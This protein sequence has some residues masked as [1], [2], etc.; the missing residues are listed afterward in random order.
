MSLLRLSSLARDPTHVPAQSRSTRKQALRRSPRRRNCRPDQPAIGAM[1]PKISFRITTAYSL[2]LLR[3][4]VHFEFS[5]S[6]LP[7]WKPQSECVLVG[8]AIYLGSQISSTFWVVLCHLSDL[9]LTS[10]QIS[11]IYH[12]RINWGI[13]S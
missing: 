8:L 3:G 5:Y 13:R 7:S 1:P 12:T 4:R 10:V 2:P 9:I 6:T 11:A